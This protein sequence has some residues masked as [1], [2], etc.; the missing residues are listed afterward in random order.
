[1]QRVVNFL[2]G[3]LRAAV[4]AVALLAFSVAV[5]FVL[6]FTFLWFLT[7]WQQRKV[8]EKYRRMHS[9]RLAEELRRK[10]DEARAQRDAEAAY[11][12]MAARAASMRSAAE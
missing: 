4:E 8:R 5:L 3:L 12:A 2:I 9:E 1:M 10:A 11:R 6:L 7:P